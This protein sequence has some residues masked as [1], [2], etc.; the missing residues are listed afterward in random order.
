M[1][2]TLVTRTLVGARALRK[3]PYARLVALAELLILAREHVIRLEP[4][5]RRRL[6]EL[7]RLSRFHPGGLTQRERREF[8]ALLAKAEPQLFLNRAAQKMTGVPIP[9]KRRDKR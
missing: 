4:D 3:L 1:A 5:E 9:R 8:T 7:V 2:G 6:V